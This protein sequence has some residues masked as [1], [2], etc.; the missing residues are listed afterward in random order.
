MK[1]LVLAFITSLLLPLFSLP[2]IG[3]DGNGEAKPLFRAIRIE[4]PIQLTGKLDDPLWKL[5]QPVN[6]SFEIQPG[7][8]IPVPQRTFAMALYTKHYLYIGFRCYDS[9]PGEIRAN[10]T[11]RD[12]IFQ[13]DFVMATLDTYGDYQRGYEFAVNPFGIQ[14]DLMKTLNNEDE[15][16][17]LV[18]HSAASRNDSGWTA[19]LAIPF[20]SLRFPNTGE[21]KWTV[22]LYRVY[23]RASRVII[24]WTQYDRNNPSDLSQAGFLL[25]L[26]D[27][28]SGG[29]FELLPYAMG[30]QTG[31]LVNT[32]DPSSTFSYNKI[33]GRVG[34]GIQYSPSSSFSLDA[35]VNP[36][37]SQIE[38]DADQISVNTTFALYYQE[39]R[40]F[41]L[42][43]QELLQTPMYYSRS[44]NNPL[45]AARVI[46]KAGPLSYVYLGAYDRNTPFDV[47]GE[48]SS[49]TFS[50]SRKSFSNIGRLRYELGNE[51]YVGS[52]IMTRDFSDGH[53]YL[54]G[55]DW[56]YKFWGNWYFAG[57][58]FLTETKELNDPGLFSSGRHFGNTQYT[59]GFDGER[60]SGSGLHLY[61]SHSSREYSF[62]IEVNNFSPTYQTYNGLFSSTGYRYAGIFQGYT[63][64]PEKSIL[65]R[66]QIQLMST[67][68]YNYEGVMKERVVQPGVSLQFK[69]Q[70]NIE[71]SYLLINDERFQG[72]QFNNIRRFIFFTRSQPISELSLEL[73]AQ[74]GKFIYRS[75][76]PEL[77]TG[78]RFSSTLTI[79][80][81]SKFKIDLSYSR[82]RLSSE[83]TNVLFFD[84]N[85]LRGVVAYQFTTEIH[86]RGIAQYNS[87]DKSFNIY[88]L[89]SYKL[90]AFTT[91]YAGVTNDY[92]D[93][94]KD[95]GFATTAR[96]FFLKVQYLLRS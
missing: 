64:Y 13:D 5:G 74:L 66:A 79:R 94:G 25:G 75:S 9:N 86:L 14:G 58:G 76:S 35:V 83:A 55:L 56:N 59:A 15:S 30:Q 2:A 78:H 20:K 23:P 11:D 27:I 62:N 10:M 45:G 82:A 6:L 50:S 54:F 49:N 41:F 68:Q 19:E 96:Q 29:S 18:W 67:I 39:K 34:G 65:D 17:D 92:L 31:S 85:I 7:E 43:G 93:Y 26:S 33:Q 89:F 12:R 57:E 1:R 38:S 32:D 70:T 90:N 51:A 24:S 46:G 52:M 95:T 80:P 77:G 48:E 44:I 4:R 84:G 3:R 47:P 42:T 53:N 88:P 73:E 81:T 40:P 71:A 60:Y 37:F 91:F 63:F 22:L 69:S 72:V 21:Q 61:L 28:E 36:D 87:F 16:F 8:N